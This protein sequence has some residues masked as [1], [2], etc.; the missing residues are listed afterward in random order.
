M[1]A[2]GDR[3]DKGKPLETI[4]TGCCMGGLSRS[5]RSFHRSLLMSPGQGVATDMSP[6]GADDANLFPAKPAHCKL[7]C[8][9]GLLSLDEQYNPCDRSTLVRQTVADE[10]RYG[11]EA[12]IGNKRPIRFSVRTKDSACRCRTRHAVAPLPSEPRS[13]P[14]MDM[15]VTCPI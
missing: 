11:A 1:T 13:W 3:V 12:A 4:D 9:D 14:G 8:V 15:V 10:L 5:D 6:A 2:N 7:P